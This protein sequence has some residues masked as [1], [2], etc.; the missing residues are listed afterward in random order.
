MY[1]IARLNSKSLAGLNGKGVEMTRKAENAAW[2]CSARRRL[3]GMAMA[4]GMTILP[5]MATRVV[6]QEATPTYSVLYTFTGGADGAYP[7]AGL[8]A[9][10][11]GNLY[12]TTE[13]GGQTGGLCGHG[14]GVIFRLDASGNKSVLYAFTGSDGW[15]P[16]GL[17]LDRAGNLYGT[18]SLGGDTTCNPPYGCG[19]VFRL[20]PAG[21]ENVL[22]TFSSPRSGAEPYTALARD[23]AGN[24]YGT[25]TAGG[26]NG[27]P[28]P[29]TAGCGVLFRLDAAG[30]ETVLHTFSGGADGATP[31][32]ALIPGTD[33]T[34]YGATI[35]GG[36]TTAPVC[37]SVGCG[38]VF[39]LSSAGVAVLHTFTGGSDGSSPQNDGSLIRDAAGNL[40][41]TAISGGDSNCDRP[42]GCGVVF[43]LDSAGNETVLHSFT[44]P[45]GQGPL[46]GVI[47]DAS[48]N[49]YGTTWIGG[50]YGEGVVYMMSPAGKETVLY[51]FTGGADGATPYAP[52]LAYDGYLYGTTAF[53]G[54]SRCSCG[55]VFRIALH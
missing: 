15:D 45:D 23:A 34:F 13:S 1:F 6:A 53:G 4:A 41:G 3:L 5:L 54:N 8:I 10:G 44:G 19:V 11:A 39:E 36:N 14:C 30:N 55:V 21:N 18:T 31:Y 32:T 24:L 38:V 9:D 51:S 40:Y 16:A 47:Q 2:S 49:L 7:I 35:N 42:Y 26:T 43:K 25:A 37:A 52:L 17:I 46:S 29:L 50:S 20:D 27:G 28:C 33:G 48:G 22:Y 12:G